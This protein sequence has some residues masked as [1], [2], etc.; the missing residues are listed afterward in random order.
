MKITPSNI[1]VSDLTLED[2]VRLVATGLTDSSTFGVRYD[3]KVYAG[4]EAADPDDC[5]EDKCAKVLLA[6][7]TINV[8]DYE[9]DGIKYDGAKV[10]NRV[11]DDDTADYIV[12]LQNI[13]DG[14]QN[15]V[16][17]NFIPGSQRPDE[18]EQ[19]RKFVRRAFDSFA[20]TEYEDFDID[21]AETLWQVILFNEWIYS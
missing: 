21:F 6:G 7:G 8:T 14:L 12:T 10:K 1:T 2:L 15:A 13:T 4:L 11:N 9:A 16:N 19:E 3:K 5:L 17:G 18:I 20:D